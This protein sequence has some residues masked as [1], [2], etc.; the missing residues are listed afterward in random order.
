MSKSEGPAQPGPLGS[1]GASYRVELLYEGPPALDAEQVASRVQSRCPQ[2]EAAAAAGGQ[3]PILFAHKDHLVTFTD[4]EVEAPVTAKTVV[5]PGDDVVDVSALQRSAGQTRDWEN[6][7]D[8]VARCTV[9]VPVTDLFARDLEPRERLAIFQ[10]VLLGLIEANPPAAIHW[11]PAGKLVDPAALLRASGSA[12]YDDLPASAINVRLFRVKNSEDGDLLM[13]TLGLAALMLPD[14]QIHFHGLEPAS[15]AAHLYAFGLHVL[16][17]GDV[18]DD[19]DAVD[20]P[21]TG[22]TWTCW[23]A[24]ASL[25]EPTRPVIDLDP[26]P[27]YAG[28]H[29]RAV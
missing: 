24:P 25:V 18:L 20:G 10:S 11:R 28:R 23:H 7:A 5:F 3:P 8:A 26:G 1:G 12:R 27:P 19:G 22:Q 29:A 16:R 4:G 2:A 9:K 6:A 14:L 13:D 17:H 21:R 15:V